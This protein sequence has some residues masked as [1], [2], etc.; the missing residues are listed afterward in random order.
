MTG[1][2]ITS[3]SHWKESTISGS[4]PGNYQTGVALMAGSCADV[5]LNGNLVQ[6][7]CGYF[8]FPG[9]GNASH[10]DWEEMQRLGSDNGYADIS[11]GYDY[12][13][14]SF[15][16]VSLPQIGRSVMGSLNWGCICNYELVC[17]TFTSPILSS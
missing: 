11:Y 6:S 5:Y 15:D 4:F 12:D 1:A 7:Q 2:R 8:M 16:E 13:W 17:L 10:I 3:L 9:G 14:L